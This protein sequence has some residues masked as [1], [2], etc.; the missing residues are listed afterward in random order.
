MWLESGNSNLVCH[1]PCNKLI[2]VSLNLSVI[3]SIPNSGSLV[4]SWKLLTYSW[5]HGTLTCHLEH[6]WNAT[7]WS[8]HWTIHAVLY[9]LLLPPFLSVL[10]WSFVNGENTF[11]AITFMYSGSTMQTI[12]LLCENGLKAE[13]KSSILTL[14]VHIT[15]DRNLCFA[16]SCSS[17]WDRK[18][19][20]CTSLLGAERVVYQLCRRLLIM[21]IFKKLR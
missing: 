15:V 6:C 13:G 16:R 21:L 12:W 8:F 18:K 4:A 9:T 17:V 3:L 2:F 19:L 10:F 1:S 11:A 5:H 20:C 14:D 7:S